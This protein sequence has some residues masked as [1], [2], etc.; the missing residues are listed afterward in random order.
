M[1]PFSYIRVESLYQPI[2]G[3]LV[4]IGAIFFYEGLKI[5]KAAQV[6]F[7]ELCAPFSTAILAWIF[8]NEK[9]TELQILGL[10]LLALGVYFISKSE[11]E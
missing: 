10:I 11:R 8:L 6:G 1:L 4:G 3:I 9:I 7:I 2:I 5:L